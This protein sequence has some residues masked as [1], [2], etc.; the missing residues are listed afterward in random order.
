MMGFNVRKYFEKYANFFEGMGSL[1]LFPN[2]NYK[3]YWMKDNLTPQE[4]DAL[5]INGDWEEVGSDF[6]ISMDNFKKSLSHK[7]S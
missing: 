2:N 7:L 4:Q 6:K 1:S 3:L 5:A